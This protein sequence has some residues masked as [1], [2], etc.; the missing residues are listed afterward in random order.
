MRNLTE[1]PK[2]QLFPKPTILK[3]FDLFIRIQN[4]SHNLLSERSEA[5]TDSAE[6]QLNQSAQFFKHK[7]GKWIPCGLRGN[8][9]TI[10]DGHDRN[11]VE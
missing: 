6:P 9:N 4:E 2:E 1:K 3:L 10:A 8:E 7:T 5:L 11:Q